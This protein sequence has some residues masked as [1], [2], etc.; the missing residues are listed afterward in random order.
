MK[1]IMNPQY[2]GSLHLKI[3]GEAI[4]NCEKSGKNCEIVNLSP[5]AWLRD[6]LAEYNRESDWKKFEDIRKHIEKPTSTIKSIKK[7]IFFKIVIST[8]AIISVFL[9]QVFCWKWN[10][11]F[12]IGTF[13]AAILMICF[14]KRLFG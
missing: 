10:L 11:V 9:A 6:P 2:N 14:K 1:R 5:D 4:N 13:V 3:F 8:F 7:N 12:G